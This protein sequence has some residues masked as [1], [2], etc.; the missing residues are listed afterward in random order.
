MLSPLDLSLRSLKTAAANWQLVVIR[1]MESVVFVFLMLIALLATIIPVAIKAGLGKLKISDTENYVQALSQFLVEQLPVILWTF[2]V[3]ILVALLMMVI[4]SLIV[5]G[6]ARVYLDAERA[7]G[8]AFEVF[9][10]DSFWA[11]ARRGF[12][13]VFWIYNLAWSLALL[14]VLIPVMFALILL[15]VMQGTMA[16]VVLALVIVGCSMALMIPIGIITSVWV[17]RAIIDGERSQ[18]TARESLRVARRNIRVDLAAHVVVMLVVFVVSVFAIFFIAGC[19]NAFAS[20]GDA[21]WPMQWIGSLAQTIAGSLAGA[22][23]LAA[24]AALA[25]N[26]PSV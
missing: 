21:F 7:P 20:A 2:A 11:A 25:E 9:R 23:M 15:L 5:A 17:G 10:G 12:W 19:V 6:S 26:G 1:M 24:F 4:H 22:W 14:F 13:R 16:A 8:D 3:L 18:L